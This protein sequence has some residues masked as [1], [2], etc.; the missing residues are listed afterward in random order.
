MSGSVFC[1]AGGSLGVA[2]PVTA[3]LVALAWE[4]DLWRLVFSGFAF[5]AGVAGDKGDGF[6]LSYD[7]PNVPE[8][9]VTG[10]DG[11]MDVWGGSGCCTGFFGA[12]QVV[13][14]GRGG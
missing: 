3:W 5:F 9:E 2:P 7:S 13:I 12:K 8:V 6:V 10:A 1:T 14:G 4:F 11:A